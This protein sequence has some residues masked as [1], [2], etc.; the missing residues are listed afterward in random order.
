MLIGLVKLST[1]C[2]FCFLD[3][4]LKFSI[5]AEACWRHS[6]YVSKDARII[7]VVRGL[8]LG[9]RRILHNRVLDENR[10]CSCWNWGRSYFICWGLS[11][12]VIHVLE[13]SRLC[14]LIAWGL[15][16]G[17]YIRHLLAYPELAYLRLVPKRVDHAFD[18][19]VQIALVHEFWREGLPL[20]LVH[21]DYLLR[22]QHHISTTLDSL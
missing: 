9:K 8:A 3:I 18:V 7:R 2:T 19:G 4:I 14:C 10:C 1:S 6:I 17:G 11:S 15:V 13:V 12:I 16:Q 5:L 22:S 21:A 20:L